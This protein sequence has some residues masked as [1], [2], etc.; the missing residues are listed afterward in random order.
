MET[1][2]GVAWAG[3][4]LVMWSAPPNKPFL[5][6]THFSASLSPPSLSLQAQFYLLSSPCHY[7]LMPSVSQV[8]DLPDM[9]LN[10]GTFPTFYSRHQLLVRRLLISTASSLKS[11]T[12][13]FL[14]LITETPTS[15]SGIVSLPL[16]FSTSLKLLLL[17]G[18]QVSC[19]HT[20]VPSKTKPL[21]TIR[22]T[23]VIWDFP[24]GAVVKNPPASAG[25]TG[26]SPGLGRSHMPRSN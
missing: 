9:P 12:Q 11:W 6:E 18:V 1:W 19:D 5:F 20:S 8:E 7:P 23:N 4:G 16:N 26:S 17:F 13:L 2:G 22:S 3:V 15:L 25:D 24:G 21:R 10:S 14:S